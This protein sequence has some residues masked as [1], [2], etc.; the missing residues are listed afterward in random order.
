[1]A[2]AAVLAF[3]AG[4][5]TAGVLAC[6]ARLQNSIAAGASAVLASDTDDS[7]KEKAIRAAALAV[8]G[9]SLSLA[10]RVALA[11][12]IG[13][14]PLIIAHQMRWAPMPAVFKMLLNGWYL[15]GISVVLLIG[16]W[17]ITKLL[18]SKKNA[19]I[20]DYGAGARILHAVA[21]APAGFWRGF[22]R[23]ASRIEG[24]MYAKALQDI[25]A[26]RPV[27]IT[28]LARGGTTALLN[29][30]AH[31]PLLASHTYRDMPFVYTPLLW[32]KL[33]GK[34][35]IA[36]QERAH[37]DGLTIDLDSPEAFDEIFWRDQWPSHY[38]KDQ[39]TPWKQSE[40]NTDFTV[41]LS[42]QMQKIIYARRGNTPGA[43]YI[44]K[45][46]AHIARLALLRAMY[47]AAQIIVALRDPAAHA[48]SLLRQHIN[49]THQHLADDFTKRYMADIG[50]YE[51]GV[52]HR[53]LGFN[54]ASLKDY[55]P[56]Q[57]D[58][59]LAYWI[60]AFEPLTHNNEGLLIITQDKLRH[61]PNQQ[62]QSLTAALG[63][64][65]QA[66]TDYSTYFHTNTD[67]PPDNMFAPK[68]LE[69]AREIYAH[70]AAKS[71]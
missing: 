59:W 36:A 37:G 50:H 49:F 38:T 63:L 56:D 26:T 3:L 68:L 29:A 15:T 58:Y 24:R 17:L 47:P 66:D 20:G 53:P 12:V 64:P 52:L 34:K 30:L 25:D 31:H 1:M 42:Q 62:I 18:P 10:L 55:Q 41:F 13:A 60:S 8:L 28:S 5:K 7:A 70:L 45:N 33:S 21:F 4:L 67:T 43:R 35:Q 48:A 14:V 23:S 54:V 46:N 19:E 69:K 32:H 44:S 11:V 65:R 71:L 27:F 2:S 9:Q 57:P 6:A 61:T 40:L 16:G 22:W 39:I 51:F